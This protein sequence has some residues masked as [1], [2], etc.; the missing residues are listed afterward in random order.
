MP[1]GP[2]VRRYAQSLAAILDGEELLDVAART[3]EAKAWLEIHKAQV[4]GQRVQSVRSRGKNLIVRLENEIFFHSHLMMWGRWQIVTK[5]RIENE[6]DNQEPSRD[7]RERARLET[8][9]GWAI[10]LSAPVFGIGRGDAMEQIEHLKTLG[11]DALPYSDEPPFDETEFL[12]RLHSAENSARAIGAAL[13]DQR[14]VCGLGNYLRAEILFECRIDPF[15]LVEELS[16]DE[17]DLLCREIPRITSFAHAC[18]GVTVPDEIRAR[19][20]TDETLVYALGREYGNRHWVFR[21]TNL[22]C[23]N[24]D[25]PIRQFRQPTW[26]DDEGERTR[27]IYFC[28]ACQ[29]T[30]VELPEIRKK[31]AKSTPE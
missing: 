17:R 2:E 16:S 24:C 25:S 27:I 8:P 11:P 30:K 31:K 9:A 12:S 29:N 18:G 13:L 5:N 22:P 15:K 6:T 14:I 28:P 7:R 10:L 4:V 23:L 1:E 3:R 19:M 20:K 26:N 21:R